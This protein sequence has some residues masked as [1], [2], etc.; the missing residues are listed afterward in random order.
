MNQKK[1]AMKLFREVASNRSCT[2]IYRTNQKGCPIGHPFGYLPC[3]ELLSHT[4]HII[5][6]EC[7]EK[8][9]SHQ[10]HHE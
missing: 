5:S 7:F 6:N 10:N 2:F 9:N 1:Q 4:S 3:A 8:S